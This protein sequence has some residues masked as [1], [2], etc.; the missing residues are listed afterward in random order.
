MLPSLN[1]PVAVNCTGAPISTNA[2]KGTTAIAV[3][4]GGPTVR[5]VEFVTDPEAAPIVLL[6]CLSPVAIP[7]PLIEATA[8][9]EDVQLTEFVKSSWLPSLNFPSAVNC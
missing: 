7:E 8:V 3:T 1:V 9:F 4:C 2:F 5:L 6:P